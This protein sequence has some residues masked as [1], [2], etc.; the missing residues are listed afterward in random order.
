MEISSLG[1]GDLILYG[2]I[3]FKIYHMPSCGWA[4]ITKIVH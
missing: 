1:G 2:L 3:G 4:M